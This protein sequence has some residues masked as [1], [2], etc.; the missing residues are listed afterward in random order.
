VADVFAVVDVHY[1]ADDGAR[2]AL[3]A[4]DDPRFASVSRERAVLCPGAEPYRPGEFYRR[5]LPPIRAVCAEA[6]PLAMLFIDGYVDLDPSGRPGLGFYVHAEFAI[7]VVGVAKNPFLTATHAVPVTRGQSSRPLYVTAAGCAV[8]EAVSV[9]RDMAG[10]FR[11]PD[12]MRRVDRLARGI[13]L[14]A[15]G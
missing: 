15:S 10:P 8:S 7:P 5:E 6:G 13:E 1:L 14:P 12:P 11:I 3:V 9:V 4:A 2:A